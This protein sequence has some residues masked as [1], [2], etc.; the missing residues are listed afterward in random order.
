M[1]FNSRLNSDDQKFL[2]KF[3]QVAR[4]PQASIALAKLLANVVTLPSTGC[5][6]ITEYYR[7]Q[8]LDTVLDSVN[9]INESS[10]IDIDTVLDL[11]LRFY[12]FRASYIYP[13][14]SNVAV[15]NETA[16]EDYFGIS[17]FISKDHIQC[18]IDNV[19]QITVLM[20]GLSEVLKSLGYITI[21]EEGQV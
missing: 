6:S 20:N 16:I 21:H 7:Q 14:I 15:C 1:L 2:L 9:T 10:I 4:T 8:C 13:K 3:N 19:L 17:R 18:I 12:Q 5:N 11:T